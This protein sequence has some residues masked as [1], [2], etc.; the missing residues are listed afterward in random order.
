MTKNIEG[1]AASLM[2]FIVEQLGYGVLVAEGLA[3]SVVWALGSR[4]SPPGTG[5]HCWP[6]PGVRS[7][8]AVKWC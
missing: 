5:H 1:P 6:I 4:P 2:Q 7:V 3:S 8:G